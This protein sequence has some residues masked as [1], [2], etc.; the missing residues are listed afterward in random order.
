MEMLVLYRNQ[1]FLVA[2]TCSGQRCTCVQGDNKGFLVSR[3]KMATSAEKLCAGQAA[4]FR[5]FC[6]AVMS[7]RFEEEPKYCALTALFEP[8]VCGAAS[9]SRPLVIDA[10]TLRV[11]LTRLLHT[12]VAWD[13]AGAAMSANLASTPVPLVLTLPKCTQML[14]RRA[15]GLRWACTRVHE[16][17]LSP[18]RVCGLI[19]QHHCL[20]FKGM[21]SNWPGVLAGGHEARAVSDR[22]AR[23]GRGGRASQEAAHGDAHLP[24]D[25]RL[26]C[27]RAYETAVCL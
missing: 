18:C 20:D 6:E 2:H 3:K 24:V 21:N 16:E 15:T 23:A 25:H 27:A 11:W 14:R 17:P 7:M 26:Q 13:A 4:P 9:P 5:R 1:C 10:N 8:L 12:E 19:A 22:A